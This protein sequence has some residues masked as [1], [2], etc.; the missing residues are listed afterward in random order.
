MVFVGFSLAMLL[1]FGIGALSFVRAKAKVSDYLVAD[2][3]I[4][5]MAAG[6]SAVASNNSG[7]MFIGAIGFTYHYGLAAVWLFIA[8]IAGDYLSWLLVH[9]RLRRFSQ[10]RDANSI[11]SFLAHDGRDIDRPLQILLGVLTLVFLSLY[12]AAQLQAGDKALQTVLDWDPGVGVLIG[13][14]LVL[15]YSFAG[16]IRA[17]IWTDVAQSM[18]MIV[19]M[20][21]LLVV[22]HVRIVPL[23][24]LAAS[25]QNIDPNLLHWTP[26]DASL[27]LIPYALGWFVAGFGGIGQPHIIIRAMTLNSE[28]GIP[29]MRRTYFS[30]Y[31]AFS[32]VTFLVG[33]YSRVYFSTTGTVDGFDPETALPMMAGAHLPELAVGLVIAALFAATMSTADSQVLACSASLTQDIGTRF[34]DSYLAAKMATFL[35]VLFSLIVALVG[36]DSVFTLVTVAWGLLA[37]CFAP[38]MVA[39]VRH[40][41]I[42]GPAYLVSIVAGLGAMLAWT[43][44]LGLGDA[45]YDGAIGFVT[46][47]CGVAL[48]AKRGPRPPAPLSPPS[49]P[50]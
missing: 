19:A 9:R 38:L 26:T 40:W 8:W 11:A 33:L 3:A 31:L 20:S 32:L 47:M 27:G 1:F 23:P 2:R 13:A 37:T 39:R 35:V 5:P 42:S 36:P 6:L 24:E 21:G 30:W 4:S 43:H 10:R 34:K 44:L 17:S 12:A 18:V 49:A 14:A 16:G 45:V 50:S 29:T 48:T 28:A 15:G 22:A 46:T 7:F 41:Q 25:L